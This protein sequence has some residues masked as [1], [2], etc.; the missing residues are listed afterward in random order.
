MASAVVGNIGSGFI[1][2]ALARRGRSEAPLLT[3]M[4]G[5]GLMIPLTLWL[6]LAPS[7]T[8][9]V[10]GVI[11]VYLSTALCFGVA[12]AALVAITPVRLRGLMVALYL[13]LGNLVGM[14]LGPLSVGALLDH[15]LHDPKQVGYALAIVS[16][17]IIMP[18]FLLLARAW[19]R[20]T[21]RAS[22]ITA[23]AAAVF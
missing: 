7:A 22:A 23:E 11:G 15:V 21:E 9:A 3:M 6:A 1:A 18:S 14:S 19:R 16:A 10:T 8:L 13:L 5:C 17:A 20:Y 4:L 2:T 12:T